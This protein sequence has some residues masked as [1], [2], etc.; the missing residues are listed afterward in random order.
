MISKKLK[1]IEYSIS[2]ILDIENKLQNEKNINLILNDK[3]IFDS[4]YSH[5]LTLHLHFGLTNNLLKNKLPLFGK[6][7]LPHFIKMTSNYKKR[8]LN[9][10]KRISK[11]I[12]H[13]N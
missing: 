6:F 7:L 13:K 3:S 8:K 1:K 5:Y 12:N 9:N 10:L 2:K 4:L 11:T